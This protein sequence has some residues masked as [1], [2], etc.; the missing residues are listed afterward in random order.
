[1]SISFGVGRLPLAAAGNVDLGIERA[2]T[3]RTT[4][5]LELDNALDADVPVARAPGG[6]ISYAAPRAARLALRHDW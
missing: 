2:L 6:P 5:R 3:P 4:L 1:M